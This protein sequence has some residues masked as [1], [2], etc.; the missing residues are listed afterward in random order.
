MS[1]AKTVRW[2]H[3]HVVA[4]KSDSADTSLQPLVFHLADSSGRQNTHF[5]CGL[6]SEKLLI[7]TINKRKK[8]KG[9]KNQREYAIVR[10]TLRLNF[11]TRE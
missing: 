9:K 1:A 10:Q 7:F 8:A 5:R 4:A 6:T 2:S 11:P 3:S